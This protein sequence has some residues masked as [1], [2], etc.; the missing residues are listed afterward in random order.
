M[1]RGGSGCGRA[2]DLG[3]AVRALAFCCQIAALDVS[4]WTGRAQTLRCVRRRFV[5]GPRDDHEG[6]AALGRTPCV[7]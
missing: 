5:G 6:N 7:P 1:P 3:R 2:A 4:L